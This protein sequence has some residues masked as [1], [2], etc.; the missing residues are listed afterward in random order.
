M[1]KIEC[2]IRP[3]KF[4]DVYQAIRKSGAGGMSVTEI[5]GFGNQRAPGKSMVEKIKIE[6]Y[7]DAFQTDSIIDTVM[8]AARTGK[9]GDGKIAVIS[10]EDM[11]RIR[12]GEKGARAIKDI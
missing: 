6:I 2:I 10:L 9:I 11:Y 1:R 7:A 8:K 4:E 3:E 5:E 12:T